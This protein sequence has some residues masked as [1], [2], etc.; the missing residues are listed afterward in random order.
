[1]DYKAQMKTAQ[2]GQNQKP[3]KVEKVRARAIYSNKNKVPH[4]RVL[5]TALR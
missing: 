1:M 2:T 5:C 3:F 4:S